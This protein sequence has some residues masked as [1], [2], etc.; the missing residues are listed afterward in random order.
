VSAMKCERCGCEHGNFQAIGNLSD[1][2]NVTLSMNRCLDALKNRADSEEAQKHELRVHLTEVVGIVQRFMQ[3]GGSPP[4]GDEIVLVEWIARDV[5]RRI[6]KSET[7]GLAIN[8]AVS[9]MLDNPI[10]CDHGAALRAIMKLSAD[11]S[12]SYG[13]DTVMKIPAAPC[14]HGG[15][16]PLCWYDGLG[17]KVDVDL[18]S[19]L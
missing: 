1:A 8:A 12:K 9:N 7:F 4:P 18:G 11:L 15:K 10:Q 13:T 3:P 2:G 19:G 5:A 17:P 14:R 6:M 16:C